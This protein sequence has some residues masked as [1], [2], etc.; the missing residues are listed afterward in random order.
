MVDAGES[1]DS[2]DSVV[3]VDEVQV[4][5][6]AAAAVAASEGRDGTLVPFTTTGAIGVDDE[7]GGEGSEAVGDGS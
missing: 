5:E 4:G 1:S 6:E 3:E 7:G 2:S